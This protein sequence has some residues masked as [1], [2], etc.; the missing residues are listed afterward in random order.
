MPY[1]G[2]YLTD[3]EPTPV[4]PI[5]LPHS[6]AGLAGFSNVIWLAE[7]VSVICVRSRVGFGWQSGLDALCVNCLRRN[8]VTGNHV[9]REVDCV[10]SPDETVAEPLGTGVPESVC[11][12]D[13][14]Q[15]YLVAD[16]RLAHYQRDELVEVIV[17]TGYIWMGPVHIVNHALTHV[18]EAKG[19]SCSLVIFEDCH[20][21]D[22]GE[23]G[24]G[25][26]EVRPCLGRVTGAVAGQKEPR[27]VYVIIGAIPR[28]AGEVVGVIR[29]A[30]LVAGP[31]PR[32]RVLFYPARQPTGDLVD[33][34]AVA[35]VE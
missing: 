15:Y 24:Y 16:P 33:Q 9:R 18:F 27:T 13:D 34:L 26:G 23:P 32:R 25:A 31:V 2:N 6:Q 14:G 29:H 17:R 1:G 19:K 11:A 5:V 8:G 10:V 3:R 20:T 12:V 22:L 4:D 7:M 35:L 28:H 30:G 21:D